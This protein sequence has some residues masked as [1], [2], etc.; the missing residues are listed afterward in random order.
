MLVLILFPIAVFAT[1]A[2]LLYLFMGGKDKVTKQT[3]T[4]L[5][6][7]GLGPQSP[8]NDEIDVRR[9]DTYSTVARLD[10]LLRK[11]DYTRLLQVKLYQAEL[12]WTPEKLL[13]LMPAAFVT[14]TKAT[15]WRLEVELICRD[16]SRKG[17]TQRQAAS[18]HN[19]WR[20]PLTS[21]SAKTR[22][23]YQRTLKFWFMDNCSR[24]SRPATFRSSARF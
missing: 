24:R 21:L 14:S 22:R 16:A 10:T 11:T 20:L 12:N 19:S 9:D 6:S 17:G 7:I 18:T 4:R 23:R 5:D 1:V 3:L 2:L 8:Q 15:G 13:K